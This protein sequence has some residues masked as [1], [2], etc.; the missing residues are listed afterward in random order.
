[1][2]EI[3]TFRHILLCVGMTDVGE[4]VQFLHK[5]IFDPV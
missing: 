2:L 4:L 3:Q 1:M 5:H